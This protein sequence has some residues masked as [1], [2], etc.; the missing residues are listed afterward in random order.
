MRSETLAE[1]V[2]RHAAALVLFAR[3]WCFVPDDVVQTAFLK[4][5]RQRTPPDNPAAWLYRVVRNGAIVAARAARRRQK[6]ETRA[7]ELSPA[8]FLPTEDPAGLDGRTV[9]AAL[10]S[11]PEEIRSIL[12]AHL[13][14]GLTFEEIATAHG[15]SASTCYR[16]YVAGLQLLRE[17]LNVPCPTSGKTATV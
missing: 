10:T 17:R 7:A 5:A 11:L 16:R 9:T 1:L 12:V 3:Q 13:W 8:W 4:L 2:D 15:G 6:Y 14:G